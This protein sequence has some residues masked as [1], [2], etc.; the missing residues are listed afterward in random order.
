MSTRY[1]RLRSRGG[2]VLPDAAVVEPCCHRGI[3]VRGTHFRA[4]PNGHSVGEGSFELFVGHALEGQERVVRLG[5]LAFVVL[6]RSPLRRQSIS[7][8]ARLGVRDGIRNWQ[9][10]TA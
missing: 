8:V 10:A 1:P 5:H 6:A 3:T 2:E 9:V 7:M 4:T